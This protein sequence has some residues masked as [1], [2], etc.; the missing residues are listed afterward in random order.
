MFWPK[1]SSPQIGRSTVGDHITTSHLVAA[2]DDRAL[3]D[4]GVLIRAVVLDQVVD[5]DAD[6]AGHRFVVVD[7]NHDAIRI[8]VVDDAAA[9]RSH[10]GAAVFRSHAFDTGTHESLLRPQH[11]HRLALHV[12]AHQRAVGIVVLEERHERCRHRDDLRRSH[13]HVLDALGRR[14]HRFAVLARA[15]Q[16]VDQLALLVQRGA[17]LG[18]DVLAFLNGRQVIDVH[19]HLAV[20]HAPV[21]RLEEAVLVELRVQRQRVD[22]A[23]VRA[24]R[25]LDRA[26][27]AVVRRVH[28]AHFEAGAFTRQTARAEGRDA[29]LV[30]DLAQ[31]VGLVHELRKLART[32]EL[33]QRGRNRL[34][35]DQVMRHQRFRLGLAEAL[36]HR[37]LDP[38]QTAAVLV[39]GQFADAAH[40]PV[41]EV[42]D[43][44]DFAAAV[45]QFDQDL[46]HVEDV[47]VRQR[48]RA[49][50]RVAPNA[51]VEFHA[52]DAAQVIAVAVVEQALEQGLH[53]VFRRRLAGAHHAVDGHPCGQFI[54][55]L[56]GSQGLTD[57]RAFVELV[58]I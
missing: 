40:A 8:D 2:L 50:G 30:R 16:L 21:R 34:R 13:V 18:D 14:Q 33:F 49:F 56:V 46:D 51:G 57:V 24:F 38:R 1:A 28:I 45:A 27:T 10:H 31:R 44:V 42:V 29:A 32:E 22:Q 26:D 6:F 41:A 54:R 58:G 36:F 3:M 17:G 15:H 39:L 19:R 9:A 52:A 5:I 53:R 20:G 43:V 55:G 47:L 12:G 4:I 35:V 37:L 11:R 25:C 48:H 7:A 23:D